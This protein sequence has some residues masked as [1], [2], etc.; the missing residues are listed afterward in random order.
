M[1]RVSRLYAAQPCEASDPAPGVRLIRGGEVLNRLS[2]AEAL[3][4]ANDLLDAILDSV[5]KDP[6]GPDGQPVEPFPFTLP[7]LTL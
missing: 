3:V 6:R 5:A 4:L 1:N 2:R 7:E